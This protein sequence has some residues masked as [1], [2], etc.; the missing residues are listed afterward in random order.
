MYSWPHAPARLVGPECADRRA[1]DQESAR[2]R[3]AYIYMQQ[4]LAVGAAPLSLNEIVMHMRSN[5]TSA[6]AGAPA[7]LPAVHRYSAIARL[8]SMHPAMSAPFA[9]ACS[10]IMHMQ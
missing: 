4:L 7:A 8:F 3:M 2:W 6:L 10:A 9:L 1:E 5:S